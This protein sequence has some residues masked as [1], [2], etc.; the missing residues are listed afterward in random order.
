ML[1]IATSLLIG[2]GGSNEVFHIDSITQINSAGGAGT[3]INS[4]GD[5]TGY[6]RTATG[7]SPN[8][9]VW[10]LDKFSN[11]TLNGIYFEIPGSADRLSTASKIHT[12]SGFSAFL[13]IQFDP[14]TT[15]G[16]TVTTTGNVPLTILSST[17][18]FVMAFGLTGTGSGNVSYSYSSNGGASFSAFTSSGLTLCDGNTHTIAVTHNALTGNIIVY[19]DGVQVATG[20]KAFDAANTGFDTIGVGNSAT[21]T[22]WGN[23]AEIRIFSAAIS[24]SSIASLHAGAVTQWFDTGFSPA[25]VAGLI[26]WW[27]GDHFGLVNS[28][29]NVGSWTPWRGS[30]SGDSTYVLANSDGTFA[31]TPIYESTDGNF[32]IPQATMGTATDEVRF[33]ENTAFSTPI[34]QPV[35][36]FTVYFTFSTTNNTYLLLNTSGSQAN[37]CSVVAQDPSH[38]IEAGDTTAIGTVASSINTPY[39]IGAVYD[40]TASTSKIYQNSHT[41]STSGATNGDT[42]TSLFTG[43]FSGEPSSWRIRHILIYSGVLSAANITSIMDWLGN[44]VGV[45]IS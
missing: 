18:G 23:V 4:V 43:S 45:T 20:N 26:A 15:P 5:Q 33:L 29:S 35:T 32:A 10:D 8:R 38:V 41:A 9:P 27:H 44:E 2:A 7:T 28:N 3:G 39:V 36:V 21:D 16:S 30:A 13:V 37:C 25:N 31:T 19:A 1:G 24:A 17:T 42:I 22:Y 14:E 6:H 40:S 11:S 12:S 34:S